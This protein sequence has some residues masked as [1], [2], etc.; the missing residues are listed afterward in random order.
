MT[1]MAAVTLC[2]L[3]TGCSKEMEGA[4]GASSAQFD[5]LKNYEDAFITRF[6]QPAATQTW[7]FGSASAGTRAVVSQPSVSKIGYSFNTTM[8]MA[9]NA[10]SA[11]GLD[12]GSYSAWAASGW[13]DEVYQVNGTVDAPNISSKLK[14]AIVKKI[15]G[16]GTEIN[17]GLIPEGANNLGKANELGYSVVTKEVGPVTL[18]PI[19]HQSSSGDPIYYYYYLKDSNPDVKTLK[20]YSIGYMADPNVCKDNIS[21]LN[22]YTYSLVYEDENGNVSYDFPAN[23]VINFIVSNVDYKYPSTPVD[24]YEPGTATQ[25]FVGRYA[26]EEGSVYQYGSDPI[27]VI[28]GKVQIKL[29]NNLSY[30]QF[31]KVKKG[32]KFTFDWGFKTKTDFEYYT[33]GNGVNGSLLGGSTVYYFKPK[34][35]MNLIIGVYLSAGKTMKVVKLNNINATSGEEVL[36]YK[37]EDQNNAYSGHQYF[38]VNKDAI[39]AVYAEGSKLGLYGFIGLP[40]GTASDTV[41]KKEF[42][43]GYGPFD[44]GS[45]NDFMSTEFWMGKTPAYFS[46]AVSE[47]SIQGY[48]AYTAGASGNGGLTGGATTYYIKPTVSGVLKVAVSLNADKNFYIK[49]LGE[50]GWNSTSGTSIPGYDGITVSSKYNGTYEFDVEA[51][52]VYAIYAEGSKLGFYGCEFFTKSSSAG[53]TKTIENHPEFYGDGYY[54]TAIHTSGLGWSVDPS[55]TPHAAV[56][57]TELTDE[58]G[59]KVKVSL[60]GFED[61]TDRDFN[62]VI[63]AVTGAEPEKPQEEITIEVPDDPKDFICRVI[64]EDLTVSQNTDFDFNDV[65]FDVYKSGLIRIRACGGTLP[66]RVDGQEVHGL[67]GKGTGEMINTGWDGNGTID[68]VNTYRDIE[69][70]KG[71]V[72]D[73]AAANLILVE[74]YKQDQWISLVAP[75]GEVASKIAVGNDYP[76]CREREDID[77]KWHLKDGTKTFS[78]YVRGMTIGNAWYQMVIEEAAKYQ[79][80]KAQR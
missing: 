58:D 4:D 55:T 12:A 56:F 51:N 11:A 10:A 6:G 27:S 32:S 44:V 57:K 63:F 52:H 59:K 23:Y 25:N 61:W 20:K 38:W 15:V 49:D 24:V 9:A 28:D 53:T 34:F 54:N 36:S 29:G 70:S 79:N 74:V 64:A 31:K 26:L 62:D 65:V 22:E 75:V 73:L 66:L 16:D 45:Y 71:G 67:F 48:N 18:T 1:V 50:G 33:E 5:I 2:G 3:F 30:P 80:K 68:Y 19:Y 14:A 8:T 46:P 41:D 76:W 39:Y 47:G 72:A 7:G 60:I 21:A 35:N 69:Y 40:Y 77:S 17:P 13:A 42:T 37:N 43:D 78:D